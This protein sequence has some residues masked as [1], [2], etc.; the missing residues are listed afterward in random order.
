MQNID[1]FKYVDNFIKHEK[2]HSVLSYGERI[3]NPYV[4]IMIPT[5][6]RPELLNQA[7]RSV[8]NQKDFIDFEVVVVDNDNLLS[9]QKEIIELLRDL[10]DNR[11]AYYCNESNLGVFGNWNRCIELAH[12]KFMTILGDDDF[13]LPEYLKQITKPLLEDESISRIE[14]K[15]FRYNQRKIDKWSDY[16]IRVIR[17]ILGDNYNLQIGWARWLNQTFINKVF[18][19]LKPIKL[20]MYLSGCFTAPHAQLYRT[21]YAKKIGGFNP[22]YAPIAD[23]VFNASYFYHYPNSYQ[24]N[25]YLCAYRILVNDSLSKRVILGCIA[26]DKKFTQYLLQYCN[27][28]SN[29]FLRYLNLKSQFL[30]YKKSKLVYIYANMYRIY[31]LF[32]NL[33]RR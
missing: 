15:Y 26:G 7:I 5:Y 31:K 33:P 12:G 17:T 29:Q 10:N 20:D 8:L 23:F 30:K 21:D 25:Y 3:F 1:Y 4:S 16:L 9:Y 6:K 18:G 22:D 19:D 14:C 13:L 28:Y 11:V 2:T 27:K 32:I 24:V